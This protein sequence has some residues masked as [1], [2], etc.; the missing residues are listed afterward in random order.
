MVVRRA[1]FMGLPRM[2]R[3]APDDD[4]DLD[5]LPADPL[6]SGLQFRPFRGA[7]GIGVDGFVDGG[8]HTETSGHG[9]VEIAGGPPRGQFRNAVFR[10]GTAP[11]SQAISRMRAPRATARATGIDDPETPAV[12]SVGVTAIILG[13]GSDPCL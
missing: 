1:D 13:A 4:R 9:L 11:E 12:V 3:F 5:L 7:G 6:Q 8:G 10:P 2:D